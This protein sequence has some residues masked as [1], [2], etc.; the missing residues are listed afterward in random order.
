[1]PRSSTEKGKGGVMTRWWD[2]LWLS[3]WAEL[4]ARQN[5]PQKPAT[6]NDF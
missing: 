6:Q 5:M 2:N 1:M 3:L 4:L